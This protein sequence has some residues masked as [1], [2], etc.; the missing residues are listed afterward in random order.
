MSTMLFNTFLNHF[1]PLDLNCI[2]IFRFNKIEKS[3]KWA[4]AIWRYFLSSIY[5]YY[6]SSQI[7]NIKFTL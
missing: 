4:D 6:F 2:Y 3:S 1:G 5:I 7:N